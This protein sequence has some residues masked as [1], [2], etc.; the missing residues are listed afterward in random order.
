MKFPM[1]QS[2][3]RIEVVDD[4]MARVLRAKSGGGAP[5]NREPDV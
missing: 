1:G 5:A 2:S 3:I 4:D